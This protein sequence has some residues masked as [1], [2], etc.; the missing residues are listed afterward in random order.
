MVM[1]S[2]SR[3][4]MSALPRAAERWCPREEFGTTLSKDCARREAWPRGQDLRIYE[5]VW[6]SNWRRGEDWRFCR[7]S[8]GRASGKP[9]QGIEP[10]LYLRRGRSEE[11]TSE[12]QSR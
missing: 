6:M 9:V 3:T 1:E 11:H 10:Y 4:R 12:L 8:K 2:D 5:S 7:D